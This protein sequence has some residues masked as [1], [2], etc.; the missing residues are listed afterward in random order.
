MNLI[1]LLSSTMLC[2][3]ETIVINSYIFCFLQIKI[4]SSSIGQYAN[5][6]RLAWEDNNKFSELNSMQESKGTA[7]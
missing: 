6:K 2:G 7:Y 5:H 1:N 4:Y 3:L